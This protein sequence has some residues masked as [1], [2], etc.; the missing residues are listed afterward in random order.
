MYWISSTEL[1]YIYMDVDKAERTNSP[2]THAI[3]S[4]K[5]DHPVALD[6]K[7]SIAIALAGIAA[8][9]ECDDDDLDSPFFQYMGAVVG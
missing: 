8:S 5:A 7:L 3:H 4:Q 2:R 1:V 6:M 9:G